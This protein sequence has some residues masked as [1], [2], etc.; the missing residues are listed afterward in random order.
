MLEFLPTTFIA[1][2]SITIDFFDFAKI[3]IILSTASR[4]FSSFPKPGP[5]S[6]VSI[7]LTYFPAILRSSGT[8]ISSSES[9]FTIRFGE[10]LAIFLASLGGFKNCGE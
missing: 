1:S 7:F 8:S 2:A 5:I 9:S 3:F 6:K 4:V 10:N